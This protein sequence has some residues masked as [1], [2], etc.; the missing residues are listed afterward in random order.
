MSSV[1]YTK[2]SRKDG[3]TTFAFASRLQPP[4]LREAEL[5]YVNLRNWY[6]EKVNRLEQ[7]QEQYDQGKK[8]GDE[9]LMKSAS[10][11]VHGIQA[12][13]VDIR[14]RVRLMGGRSYAEAFYFVANAM[15]SVE[16]RKAIDEETERLIGRKRHELRRRDK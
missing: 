10:G 11:I 5:E 7:A 6:A 14:D 9:A 3:I 13:L 1:G 2:G 8:A 16:A 12:D 15:L 4:E